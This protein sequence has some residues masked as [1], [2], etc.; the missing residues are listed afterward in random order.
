M[1]KPW[2]TKD[3]FLF[4]DAVKEKVPTTKCLCCVKD[5][6]WWPP[7]LKERELPFFSISVCLWLFFVMAH[8]LL[9]LS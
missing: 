1:S 5:F 7:F 3:W 9:L 4:I 6:R 2:K 8:G